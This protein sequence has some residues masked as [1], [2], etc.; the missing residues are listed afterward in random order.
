MHGSSNSR[1]TRRLGLA[2]PASS[3]IRRPAGK[4]IVVIAYRDLHGMNAWPASGRD[5]ATYLQDGDSGE[6]P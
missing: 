2:R 1:R 4:L 6:G 3:D 5:L